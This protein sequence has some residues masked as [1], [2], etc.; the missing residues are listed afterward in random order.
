MPSPPGWTAARYDGQRTRAASRLLYA[1][2]IGLARRPYQLSSAGWSAI[3][4]TL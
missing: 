2:S 3:P 1:A 4:G